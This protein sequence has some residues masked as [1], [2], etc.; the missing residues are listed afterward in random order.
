MTIPVSLDAATEKLM[1]S[2]MSKND[3]ISKHAEAIIRRHYM[4]KA[5]DVAYWYFRLNGFLTTL[6][7][8]VHREDGGGMRT[9]ADLTGIRFANH[10]EL[11][12]PDASRFGKLDKPMLAICEVTTGKCKLNGPWS[13]Q[14]DQP[15]K[16]NIQYV[17]RAAGF[18]NDEKVEQVAAFLYESCRYED[19]QIVVQ[20]FALGRE[21]DHSLRESH[22]ELEQITFAEIL[23]FIFDRFT[24]T[25]M[26]K[27]SNQQWPRTGQLLFKYSKNA[28]REEYAEHIQTL[29][30][31]PTQANIKRI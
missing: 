27:E 23:G 3:L 12:Y 7:F 28:Q 10:R 1:R 14:P 13:S 24:Q 18:F 29:M 6:N 16:K 15:E 30:G 4:L 9:D 20:M 17:L 8:I 26:V 21:L 5:D 11:D 31:I 2:E 19:A 25:P 22:P